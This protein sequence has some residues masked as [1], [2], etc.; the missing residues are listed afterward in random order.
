[1]ADTDEFTANLREWQLL[2]ANRRGIQIYS[3]IDEQYP[4]SRQNINNESKL[5]DKDISVKLMQS[6]W[7]L[8]DKPYIDI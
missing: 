8:I 7:D 1:M 3:A 6:G 4:R 5:I 2:L